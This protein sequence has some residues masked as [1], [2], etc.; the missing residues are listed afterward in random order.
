MSSTKEVTQMNRT[1]FFLSLLITFGLSEWTATPLQKAIACESGGHYQTE[2]GDRKLPFLNLGSHNHQISTNN[3]ITQRYFNQGL[4]LA[5]GFNHAE[6]ERSFRE[7][8][9]LDPDCAMCYWGIAL[10]LGPNINAPMDD[11]AVPKAYT[12]LQKAQNLAPKASPTEQ[13]YIQAL[14]KRYTPQPVKDRTSLD[15]DYAKAMRELYQRYPNDLDAATLYAE[16]LMDLTPWNF[17]TKDGQPTTYTNEIVSTLES[18]LQRHPN[19]PGANHYYIHAVEASQTPERAIPSAQRLE[20]L[21]PDAGHL[22]HM[23]SH[24]YWRVG[25]YYDA[26]RINERAIRVDETHGV[27]GTRDQNVHSYYALAYYPHNIHFLF[28]AAQMSGRSTLALEAAR[29]LVAKIPDRAYQDVPALEDFKPMPLFAL[30]RFGKWQEILQEPQPRSELQYTTGMWHWA[31]GL[32]YVRRGNLDQAKSEYAQLRKIAQTDAMKELTLASFPQAST[33]LDIA[34]HVLASELAQAQ[35][36][37]NE[38]IAQL[39]KA[40]SIQ[41]SLSYIEPPSW[42]YPVRHNLGYTLLNVGQIQ[43]AE[44]VYRE[45]LKQYPHNGW[46]LFGLVQSLQAQGKTKEAQM[47]QQQFAAAW[48]YADVKLT[49]SQF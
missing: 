45:D 48:K 13:A 39:K 47:I 15:R 33:L 49:A 10:V 4:I 17:W 41:D 26:A 14:A 36:Q 9:R 3:P 12:A 28:A 35:G 7:A 32:A 5:Y 46:S 20:T 22:V 1:T 23:P 11:A 2:A 8:A 29:K 16:A 38:A 25:R 37:T 30:V 43:E 19:H 24:V 44:A 31:R 42:Y 6:A 34:S 27:G 21:V 40:V 18:V